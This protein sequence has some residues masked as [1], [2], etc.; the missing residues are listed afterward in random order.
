MSLLATV[1]YL[2]LEADDM[3]RSVNERNI[4]QATLA[5]ATLTNCLVMGLHCD[6]LT[7]LDAFVDLLQTKLFDTA[8]VCRTYR[9]LKQD[10]EYLFVKGFIG[11]DEESQSHAMAFSGL[12][13]K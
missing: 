9:K 7:L 11:L 12:A 2:T 1:L 13:R 8:P 6:L 4:A 10:L 5:T 3:E